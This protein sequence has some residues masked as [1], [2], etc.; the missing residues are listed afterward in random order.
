MELRHG[1]LYCLFNAVSLSQAFAAPIA[2]E[3]CESIDFGPRLG[4]VREQ[5]G[6]EW[7]WAMTAAD[8]I[9]FQQG[10]TPAR[11]VA[12]VDVA[13]AGLNMTPQR[14]KDSG[15]ATGSFSTYIMARD[16][17]DDQEV[18]AVRKRGLQLAGRQGWSMIGVLAYNGRER[19]CLESELPSQL[20]LAFK[21]E[22]RRQSS[23]FPVLSDPPFSGRRRSARQGGYLGEVLKGLGD[24][25]AD[26]STLSTLERIRQ[27]CVREGLPELLAFSTFLEEFNQVV[28]AQVENEAIGKCRV[29]PPVKTMA[30]EVADFKRG[31]SSQ[32][33]VTAAKWLRDGSPFGISLPTA[34]LEKGWDDKKPVKGWHEVVLSGMRWNEGTGRCDFK[35]RNSY[36]TDCSQYRD[37]LKERCE[38]GNLWL[39]ENELNQITRYSTRIR[40]TGPAQ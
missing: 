34:F 4:P 28:L 3:Q 19:V 40:L 37:G 32:A 31:E 23:F 15:A 36:G 20:P 35:I 21:P 10:I 27:T 29:G 13:L 24:R 8:L 38:G 6:T 33:S 14:I 7:C 12:V 16:E 26:L 2:R 22:A 18:L 17:A 11:Q 39:S 9:G 30:G 25:S 5:L 1:L